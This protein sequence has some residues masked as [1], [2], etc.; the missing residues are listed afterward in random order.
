MA[1]TAGSIAAVEG[2]AM[3]CDRALSAG[4][5]ALFL[6][7]SNLQVTNL[8]QAMDFYAWLERLV[9]FKTC[10]NQQAQ[11]HH[12]KVNTIAF[13]LQHPLDCMG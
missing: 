6:S 2:L 5:Q 1:F 9:Q 12:V 8:Q 11:S 3:T 7:M 10:Y 13:Q 4:Q